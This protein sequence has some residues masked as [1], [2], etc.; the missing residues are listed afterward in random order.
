MTKYE[1]TVTIGASAVNLAAAAFAGTVNVSY[2]AA[3]AS[4]YGTRTLL[5][6]RISIQAAGGN[7]GHVYVGNANVTSIGANAD[8]QLDPN[9]TAANAGTNPLVIESRTDSNILD[10]GQFWVHGSHAADTLLVSYF[11][12]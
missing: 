11:Q 1:F 12:E 10:L 8:Y 4:V 3:W 2:P 7:T 6:S 5:C 9:A